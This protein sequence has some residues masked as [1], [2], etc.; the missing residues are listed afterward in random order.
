VASVTS[1]V[2]TGGPGD[3]RL[4]ALTGR[5]DR[6]SRSV[7]VGLADVLAH[8]AANYPRVQVHTGTAAVVGEL[9]TVGADVI[10]VHTD[11]DPPAT[12]YLSLASVSDVSFLDSG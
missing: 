3:G 1:V 9:R 12:A 5:D 2:G 10:S 8:A 4:R 7:T 11:G 6:A